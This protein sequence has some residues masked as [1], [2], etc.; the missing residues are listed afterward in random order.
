MAGNLKTKQNQKSYNNAIRQ[1]NKNDV[2]Y[3]NDILYQIRLIVARELNLLTV[4]AM[5]SYYLRNLKALIDSIMGM[6]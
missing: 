2:S 3:N 6:N 5:T 1:L 4:E